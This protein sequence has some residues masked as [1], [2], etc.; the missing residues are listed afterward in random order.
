MVRKL[1]SRT[2]VICE[3]QI[4]S[5]CAK[6]TQRNGAY[7]ERNLSLPLYIIQ[8]VVQRRK[9]QHMLVTVYQSSFTDRPKAE[10]NQ[11][12]LTVSEPNPGRSE[13]SLC[14]QTAIKCAVM[15]QTSGISAPSIGFPARSNTRNIGICWPSGV[16]DLKKWGFGTTRE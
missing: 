14:H 2:E 4:S 10:E 5:A 8:D 12:L 9:Q 6:S 7:I 15:I 1:G 13:N 16:T 3:D 11:S